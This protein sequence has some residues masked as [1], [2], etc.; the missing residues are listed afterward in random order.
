MLKQAGYLYSLGNCL[1][2]VV[3]HKIITICNCRIYDYHQIDLKGKLF[4]RKIGD[5]AAN[6]ELR[7]KLLIRAIN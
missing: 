2:D 5:A 3:F 7:V 4:K 6:Y 1:Y